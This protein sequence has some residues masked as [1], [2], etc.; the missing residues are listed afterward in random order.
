MTA[1]IAHGYSLD[2]VHDA[3]AIAVRTALV[4]EGDWRDR[5]HLAA[6]AIAET[7]LTA[8]A[9]PE[10][11]ELVKV[12]RRAL[13]RGVARYCQM[14]GYYQHK[15]SSGAGSSP[16]FQTY[17]RPLPSTPVEDAV[18]DPL[19][20][21]QIWATLTPG[22]RAA[23]EALADHDGDRTAAAA[24][25]GINR[26]AFNQIVAKGRRRFAALWHEGE[27]PRGKWRPDRRPYQRRADTTPE[28]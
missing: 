25:L 5:H 3:A 27:T 23:L 21:A 12:G 9:H 24:E 16:A 20:L 7:L 1:P 15:T 26:V 18:V 22:Q 11:H 4:G 2:G 14:H 17:W 28:D 6:S 13:R 8:S 19:A 10:R